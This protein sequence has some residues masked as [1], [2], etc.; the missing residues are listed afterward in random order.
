MVG[1][2]QLWW[3]THPNV[4]D[5][6]LVPVPELVIHTLVPILELTESVEGDE[7]EDDSGDEVWEISREEWVGSSPEL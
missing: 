7:E 1:I 3:T 5:T 6:A 2:I 4:L